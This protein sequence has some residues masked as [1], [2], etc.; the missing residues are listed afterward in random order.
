[1]N[2]YL[3][4][5]KGCFTGLIISNPYFIL[6]IENF[7]D[8]CHFCTDLLLIIVFPNCQQIV[9]IKIIN[10]INI[11][12]IT[13]TYWYFPVLLEPE[14]SYSDQN[15]I[16]LTIPLQFAHLFWLEPSIIIFVYAFD[17][18][19]QLWSKKC[20]SNPL[21]ISCSFLSLSICSILQC[22]YLPH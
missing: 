6:L 21:C 19:V 5:Y 9:V 3:L 11:F 15:I 4:F 7:S 10:I 14:L 16:H 2:L 17:M 20:A 12:T 1:M 8:L 22:P 18:E 13:N